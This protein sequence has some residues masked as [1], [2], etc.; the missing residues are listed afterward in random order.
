M[1]FVL[2]ATIVI[3]LLLPLL[4]M[5]FNGTALGFYWVD[6]IAVTLPYYWRGGRVILLGAAPRGL[7]GMNWIMTTV[8]IH[9]GDVLRVASRLVRRVTAIVFALLLVALL[10]LILMTWNAPLRSGQVNLVVDLIGL[11]ALVI[12]A[13]FDHIQSIVVAALIGML[14][15]TYSTAQPMVRVAAVSAYFV[16]QVLCYFAVI[17]FLIWTQFVIAHLLFG[18]IV[19]RVLVAGCGLVM[20]YMLREAL[21]GLLW[22][23]ML[24]RYQAT[25]DEF[26]EA[27]T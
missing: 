16:M 8:C 25:P 27:V 3:M 19:E 1:P 26:M 24:N 5:F 14:A 10:G 9:R 23:V 22:R 13:W 11:I 6:K 20:F 12:A 4:L 18:A 21:I 2:V 15:P 17:I 7:P